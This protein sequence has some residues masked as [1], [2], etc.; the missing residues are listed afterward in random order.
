MMR[1]T[2]EDVLR[3]QRRLAVHLPATPVIRTNDARGWLKLENV[4]KTG[5]YKV[6]GALNALLAQV[7]RG[8]H[9]NIIAGIVLGDSL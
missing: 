9:R 7:E 5:A 6:R 1:P 4:Q 3:A 8:D 2:Y